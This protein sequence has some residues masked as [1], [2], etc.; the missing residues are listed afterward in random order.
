MQHHGVEVKMFA[1]TIQILL[2]DEINFLRQY[3]YL[4]NAT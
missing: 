3:E 2:Q 4:I 1:I